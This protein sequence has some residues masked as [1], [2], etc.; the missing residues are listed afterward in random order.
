MPVDQAWVEPA[1]AASRHLPPP[2]AALFRLV[3]IETRRAGLTHVVERC[4]GSL[5]ALHLSPEATARTLR[6][7]AERCGVLESLHAMDVD[8]GGVEYGSDDEHE[9]GNDESSADALIAIAAACRGLSQLD[10]AISDA[11]A[12]CIQ[13]VA[14]TLGRGLRALNLFAI[15]WLDE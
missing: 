7:V 15:T 12:P 10:L 13:A 8:L 11:K 14:R 6:A 4:G 5:T 2:P 3:A 9:S 1:A